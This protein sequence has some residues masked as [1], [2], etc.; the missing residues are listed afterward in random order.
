MFQDGVSMFQ[1]C[2]MLSTLVAKFG[3]WMKMTSVRK[4][5][6]SGNRKSIM[7]TWI[8]SSSKRHCITASST[9]SSISRS[10]TRGGGGWDGSN[11]TGG[12]W[13]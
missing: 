2:V 5:V 3:P 10:R 9:I 1:G 8:R 6:G 13:Q 4:S 12:W 11:W 7:T